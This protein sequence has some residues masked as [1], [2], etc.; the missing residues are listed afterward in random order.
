MNGFEFSHTSPP[1]YFY[2]AKNSIVL[3][4]RFKYRKSKITTPDDIRTEEEI[5]YERG[6][7]KIFDC[8]VH[9]FVLK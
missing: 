8:G 5:M 9:A 6:Y 4:H 7:H 1:S 2:V 3:E